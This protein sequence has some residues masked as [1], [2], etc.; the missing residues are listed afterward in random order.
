MQYSLIIKNDDQAIV[1]RSACGIRKRLLSKEDPPVA[2]WVHTVD[3]DDAKPHFHKKIVEIYY[4]LEGEGEIILQGKNYKITHG[5]IVHIP[6][7]VVHSAKG[8]MRVLVIGIPNI[9]EDDIFYP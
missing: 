2:A 8:K 9:A 7:N 5:S 3:I 4:V 1:E 6:Q